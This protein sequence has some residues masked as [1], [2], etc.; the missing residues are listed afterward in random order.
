MEDSSPDQSYSS[1][2]RTKQTARKSS[3]GRAPLSQRRRAAKSFKRKARR[4]SAETMP[5]FPSKLQ[6]FKKRPVGRRRYKN[7]EKALL[8][9]SY[10]QKST[11]YLIPKASFQRLVR[12]IMR[13][14]DGDIRIT[15]QAMA[16][17]HEASE[18]YL[19]G[20]LE[21]TNLA[22]IHAKRVTIQQKDQ[23]L[24]S[25]LRGERT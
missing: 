19:V 7:G 20:H 12:D 22:A 25:V 23:V 24:I 3:G 18:T 6:T 9:I 11:C 2:I 10:Y 13:G 21:D 16:A 17:L 14:H 5:A 8:E 1:P 4:Q 15:K